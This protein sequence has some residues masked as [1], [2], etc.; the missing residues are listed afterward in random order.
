MRISD[1]NSELEEAYSK[2]YV[3][4]LVAAYSESEVFI[5]G[6]AARVPPDLTLLVSIF[7]TLHKAF[8][9]KHEKAL[10]LGAVSNTKIN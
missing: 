10:L 4:G 8:K 2:G 1:P 5:A 9:S 7:D 3:D 6:A